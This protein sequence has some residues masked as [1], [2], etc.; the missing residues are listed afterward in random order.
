MRLPLPPAPGPRAWRRARRRKPR[1]AARG[2][3]RRRAPRPPPAP[4]TRSRPAPRH[5]PLPAPGLG[6]ARPPAPAQDRGRQHS[7]RRARRAAGRGP[8]RP[9]R[10]PPGPR[11]PRTRRT[12][13]PPPR[14]PPYGPAA[15][16]GR[17]VLRRPGPRAPARA[18][19]LCQAPGR[20]ALGPVR[21]ALCA[22]WPAAAAQQTSLQTTRACRC[23]AH[24]PAPPPSLA[25]PPASA[26]LRAAQTARSASP[27]WAVTRASSPAPGGGASAQAL[28]QSRRAPGT[29]VA[30][31]W[32]KRRC[33]GDPRSL[34]SA[35]A[36]AESIAAA[37]RGSAASTRCACAR[38]YTSRGD[39]FPASTPRASTAFSALAASPLPASLVAASKA[40]I[41]TR[42]RASVA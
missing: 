34:A 2:P 39:P 3:R 42:S 5:G 15:G 41:H 26:G 8:G 23:S 24:S 38:V 17:Q 6:P 11:R 13:P 25:V 36:S 20:G 31:P 40:G 7:A 22:R 12:A 30:A 16:A 27:G 1:S 28:G 4:G 18:R 19:P 33:R 14:R 9:R 21:A 32:A 35:T 37:T 10:C 29:V